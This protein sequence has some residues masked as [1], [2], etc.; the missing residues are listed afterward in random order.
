VI[1]L[2][3]PRSA[4]W[5]HRLPLSLMSLGA[6]LEGKYAYEIV[7]GNFESNPEET[8]RRI[9]RE[10]GIRY[11]GVTVMPG[12]QLAQAIT[13]SR[14]LKLEFPDLFVVWGGYFPS[15]HEDVCL[16]SGFVDF[17]IKGRGEQAFLDLIAS[18]ESSTPV[19]HSVDGEASRTLPYHRMDVGR[20]IGKTCLGSRTVSY[21]SSFGCPYLCGFCSVAAIYK[22]RWTGAPASAVVDDVLWLRD[23]YGVNAVEFIDNNFFVA[24]HRTYEIARRLRGAGVAWWGEARP[25]TLMDF[26]D[27]TWR[28]MREGGCKMIFLGAESSSD[29]VLRQM[30]KGGTQ[31]AD[32]VLQ[33]AERI[34][35]FEIVP[36]FSFVLGAPSNDVDAQID[37][38]IRY[39][40]RIKEINPTSEIVIY[41]YSP[42][43][44]D[45]AA[46]LQQARTF[47]FQFPAR[48]ID[49]LDPVWQTFALRK[50]PHTPWLQSRHIDR[51]MNFERVLNARYPTISDIKLTRWQNRILKSLGAWR[52]KLGFYAAPW[53]IRLVANRLFHYRQPEIE[54]F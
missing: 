1:L 25:D 45:D 54:G 49:W 46:L 13:I 47:G 36:E 31:N 7:D 5:K 18:G 52:Y 39:I 28:M 51:I 21:H 26:S 19:P 17:V 2:F 29:D 22:G 40:R 32:T 24:E 34:A 44:F 11:L 23:K 43:A 14:N 38:D 50:N 33:L 6:F 15:L 41:V 12:P 53:E 37:R 10:K 48:L 30:D 35:R 16:E 27:S 4:R 8:L 3:N 20:Y 42:V 9:I